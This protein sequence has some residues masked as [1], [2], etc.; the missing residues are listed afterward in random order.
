M[1]LDLNLDAARG[2][3]FTEARQLLG[4]VETYVLQ[5]EQDPSD[6]ETLNAAF[7]AAH[8]IK[9]SAGVFGFAGVTHFVHDLETVLDRVRN[10]E[11]GFD[12]PMSTLVLSC[13]DHIAT[14]VDLLDAGA[15]DGEVP[16]DVKTVQQGLTARLKAYLQGNGT[17]KTVAAAPCLHT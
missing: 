14:L 4:E 11:I 12:G 3:F 13:R 7:R 16:D 5:L 1:A 10:G 6:K 15:E 9:G 17:E 8:T 2:I